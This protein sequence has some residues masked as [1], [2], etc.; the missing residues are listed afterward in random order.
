MED[1]YEKF[2]NVFVGVKVFNEETWFNKSWNTFS[3]TLK[4][5]HEQKIKLGV[6]KKNLSKEVFNHLEIFTSNYIFFKYWCE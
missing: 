4:L 5:N 6:F 2:I 3:R 1:V